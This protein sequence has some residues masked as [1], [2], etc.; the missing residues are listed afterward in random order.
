MSEALPESNLPPVVFSS[1]EAPL[2]RDVG[3]LGRMLGRV[4]RDQGE[5]G[6]F[7]IVERVRAMCKDLRTVYDEHRHEELQKLLEQLSLPVTVQV[8]RAFALYFQLVNIAEQVHRVRRRRAHRLHHR[9]PPQQGSIEDLVQ[10]LAAARIPV[11]TIVE[12]L[13]VMEITLVL[14][15]HPTE[16]TR[17]TI[18][19]KQQIISEL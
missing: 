16:A 11:E 4:L 5:S 2:R 18:L 1:K 15:A 17:L 6:L 7:D 14:T 9:E 3:M 8:A 10:R 19:R 13:A 12:R